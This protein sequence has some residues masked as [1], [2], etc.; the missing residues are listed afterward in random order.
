MKNRYDFVIACGGL[1]T[2]LRAITKEIL[3]LYTQF[4]RKVQLK[5]VFLKSRIFQIPM[6]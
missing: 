4:M 1:G 5:D 6:F 3:N 2:R